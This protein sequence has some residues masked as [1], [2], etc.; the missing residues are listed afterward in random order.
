MGRTGGNPQG[1]LRSPPQPPVKV[2]NES[3]HIL[4][5]HPLAEGEERHAVFV[6]P[7][8]KAIAEAEQI[9]LPFLAEFEEPLLSKVSTELVH[10]RTS[11]IVAAHRGHATMRPP[12][13]EGRQGKGAPCTHETGPG[14]TLVSD[15]YSLR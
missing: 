12:P 4:A 3:L 15:A 2:S 1:M 9:C 7:V 13:P 5:G 6:I 10:G 8:V 11:Q 14:E